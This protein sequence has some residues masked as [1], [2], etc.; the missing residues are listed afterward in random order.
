MSSNMT[1]IIRLFCVALACTPLSLMAQAEGDEKPKDPPTILVVDLADKAKLKRT[2]SPGKY[3]LQIRNKLPYAS[4]VLRASTRRAAL[5]PI[6]GSL[7]AAKATVDPT[8]PCAALLTSIEN[9]K[10][11]KEETRVPS[12]LAR[13][14]TDSATSDEKAC[15]EARNSAGAI[16][17]ATRSL[18]EDVYDVKQDYLL[19]AIVQRVP[20]DGL[21]ERTWERTFTTVDSRWDVSY[22]YSFASMAATKKW[23]GHQTYFSKAVPND[24]IHYVITAE[25]GMDRWQSTATAFFNYAPDRQGWW[26]LLPGLGSGLAVDLEKPAVMLGALWTYHTNLHITIGG[27]MHQELG[28]AGQYAPGDTIKANLT[29]DQLHTNRWTPRPFMAVSWRF[30]GNPFKSGDKK[31]AAPAAEKDEEAS[32][33]EDAK[34]EA[35]PDTTS[36]RPRPRQPQ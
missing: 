13:I 1:S 19:S 33:P 16:M 10:A 32:K 30:A 36:Q 35:K 29:R 20:E 27:L 11:E 12:H 8:S 9:L 23:R 4:Y 24:T 17:Q 6:Q 15:A 7:F 22:G 25:N 2:I 26:Q 21:A 28:L 31:E 5:E 14:R 34:K 3:Q 18:D